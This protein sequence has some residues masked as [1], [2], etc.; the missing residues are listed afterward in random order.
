MQMLKCIF[1]AL[2]ASV[3][4][5]A[6]ARG[7]ELMA[8]L[9]ADGE[10]PQTEIVWPLDKS[11]I[12][13]SWTAEVKAAGKVVQVGGGWDES[14][15]IGGEMVLEVDGT[16]RGIS[17]TVEVATVWT[18]NEALTRIL[19]NPETGF[20][21]VDKHPRATFVST[22]IAGLPKGRET[23]ATHVVKGILQFNGVKKE[24]RMPAILEFQPGGPG[25]V[26]TFT[27][28]RADFHSGLIHPPPRVFA[29]DG[30]ISNDLIITARIK[31]IPLAPIIKEEGAPVRTHGLRKT[32]EVLQPDGGGVSGEF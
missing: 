26:A 25:M 24:I 2:I 11:M 15:N 1:T 7:G 19:R 22:E 29:N 31:P 18:E 4:V 9:P 28:N 10:P 16:V 5:H 27:L 30:D 13:V 6:P 20:F 21:A 14:G 12:S 23:K 32:A 8:E 17:A 3:G